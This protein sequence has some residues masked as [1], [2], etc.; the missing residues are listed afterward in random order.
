MVRVLEMS[1]LPEGRV[2]GALVFRL[3]LG[4]GLEDGSDGGEAGDGQG[5]HPVHVEQAGG[6]LDHDQGAS[7]LGERPDRA[8]PPPDL[9]CDWAERWRQKRSDYGL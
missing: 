9:C 5:G 6:L 8:R 4:D 2:R 1:T 7:G 3:G